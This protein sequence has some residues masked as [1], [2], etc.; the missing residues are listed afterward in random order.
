MSNIFYPI[1]FKPIVE[2]NLKNIHTLCTWYI[3]NQSY[4]NKRKNVCNLGAFPYCSPLLIKVPVSARTPL[5]NLQLKANWARLDDIFEKVK[6]SCLNPD[7][8]NSGFWAR[9]DAK[10]GLLP[11]PVC[12]F[13]ALLSLLN[14]TL[15]R[16]T[17]F[18]GSGFASQFWNPVRLL[19]IL[20]DLSFQS[21]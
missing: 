21:T 2:N 10:G 19:P 14:L 7:Q 3:V 11:E 13:Q 6:T 1:S 4:F 15:S 9:N 16:F 17:D 12:L 20:L 8:L 5:N 18:S